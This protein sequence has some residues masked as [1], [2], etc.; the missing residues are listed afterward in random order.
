MYSG[1]SIHRISSV[2]EDKMPVMRGIPLLKVSNTK[3]IG[4]FLSLNRYFCPLNDCSPEM[5]EGC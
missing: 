3:I 4:A 2:H 5:N 1:T